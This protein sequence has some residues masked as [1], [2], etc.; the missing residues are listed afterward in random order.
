MVC[1]DNIAYVREHHGIEIDP[2]KLQFR[3]V[4]VRADIVDCVKLS[5]SPWFM[6]KF[7]FMVRYAQSA[8]CPQQRHARCAASIHLPP[9]DLELATTALKL[10]VQPR[11]FGGPSF[12]SIAARDH[13]TGTVLVFVGRYRRVA[14]HRSDLQHFPPNLNRGGIGRASLRH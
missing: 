2:A 14:T 10:L 3:G 12:R 8:V 4:I 9:I 13:I 11:R 1:G 5:D 7:G 6:G